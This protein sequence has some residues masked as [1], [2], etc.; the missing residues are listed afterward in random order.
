MDEH[1]L[2]EKCP[3]CGGPMGPITV[4]DKVNPVLSADLTYELPPGRPG[5]WSGIIPRNAPIRSLMC[6][7]CGLIQLHGKIKKK[8]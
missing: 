2:D 5:F 3:Q 4:K 7:D 6:R 1:E 8:Q